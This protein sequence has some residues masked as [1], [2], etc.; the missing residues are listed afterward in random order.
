MGLVVLGSQEERRVPPSGKLLGGHPGRRGAARS[1]SRPP[2]IPGETAEL[3]LN[4][5]ALCLVSGAGREPPGWMCSHGYAQTTRTWFYLLVFVLEDAHL[6]QTMLEKLAPPNDWSF[7][8][9]AGSPVFPRTSLLL[10][11]GPPGR[12]GGPSLCSEGEKDRS[13]VGRQ[14]RLQA[15]SGPA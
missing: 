10:C 7:P 1:S 9:L 12:T 6:I 8:L 4:A 11:A 3:S 5:F 14:L 15:R 13:G 2:V